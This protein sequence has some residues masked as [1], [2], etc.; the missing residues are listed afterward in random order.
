[1]YP[2]IR[3]L[4]EQMKFRGQ[5]MGLFETHVS[6]HRCWPLDLDPWME[7]NNGRTLTLFDLGRMP[8]STRTG[9]MRALR[10][11]GWG[12]TVAGSAPRYRR[13]VRLFHRVEM[14]T[15][16]LGW[17]RRFLY[18]EQSMWRRGEALNHILLRLAVTSDAGIV[19]PETLI[20]AM[21]HADRETPVLADWVQAWIDAENSRPW[22]PMQNAPVASRA[23]QTPP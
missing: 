18:T 19:P 4:K 2:I 8:F 22:P 3:L 23:A 14:R 10:R 9:L 12:M 20:A 16:L 1:M 5:P 21:G 11:N 15:R 7:L 13:R 6:H 17:D